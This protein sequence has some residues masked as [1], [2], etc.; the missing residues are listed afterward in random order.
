MQSDQSLS[1][2]DKTPYGDTVE[3]TFDIVDI[4]IGSRDADRGGTATYTSPV[5][6]SILGHDIVRQGNHSGVSLKETVQ[7]W[8]VVL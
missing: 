1:D 3:F 8:A 6:F 4:R 7:P 2:L 5:G